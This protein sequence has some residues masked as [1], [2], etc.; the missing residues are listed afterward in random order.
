MVRSTPA[1]TPNSFRVIVPFAVPSN[2]GT[3]QPLEVIAPEG[4]L[5]NALPPAA[6]AGGNVETS[7]RIVDVVLGALSKAMPDSLPA[8]SYGTMSNVTIGGLDPRSGEPFAYYET[9]AGGMGARPWA[10]GL[11][12]THCHMTNSLN[13]PIEALEHAYPYRVRRYAVRRGSGGAGRYRGGDGIEREIEILTDARVTVLSDRRT[14][15]PY[16]LAGGEPG[17]PG[18]NA[19]LAPHGERTELGGKVSVDVPAGSVL[20]IHTPGG[21]GFGRALPS[22]TRPPSGPGGLS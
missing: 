15:A 12:A 3:I 6:M 9:I 17:E 10:D 20:Q 16:G 14:G 7:Q 22:E 4:S 13:T 2:W 19:V 18:R 5:V 1:F 8:A 21:G 11:D